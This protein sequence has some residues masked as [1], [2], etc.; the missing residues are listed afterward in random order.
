MNLLPT[1]LRCFTVNNMSVFFFENQNIITIEF[2]D[3]EKL[4]KSASEAP[5]RRARYCLH[6]SH[7]DTVQEMVIA[8]CKDSIVPI[9]R[10]TDKSESFHV[11]EGEMEVLFYNDNGKVKKTIKMGQMGSGLP[12]LYRLST[13][14]WHSVKLLT[15]Y[16]VIHETTSG[17]FVEQDDEF[18]TNILTRVINV[19]HYKEETHFSAWSD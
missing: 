8:F 4:K 15:E 10:H 18:L 2:P 1:K 16:V 19:C 7:S 5:L 6:H 9:H 12:F 13:N 3:L 14:E 17:P 11:I